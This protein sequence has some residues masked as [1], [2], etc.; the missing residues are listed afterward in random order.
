MLFSLIFF[1]LSFKIGV[2]L[3]SLLSFF[4]IIIHHLVDLEL[5]FMICFDWLYIRLSLISQL[6]SLTRL[7][8]MTLFT[9]IDFL[10]NK[11]LIKID[12]HKI[13]QIK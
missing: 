11:I 7:C 4:N 9:K 5:I 3:N 2:L 12:K 8:L 1:I 13:D 6:R 10:F